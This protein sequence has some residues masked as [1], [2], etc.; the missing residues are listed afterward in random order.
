MHKLREWLDWIES[1]I[2]PTNTEHLPCANHF[3][4]FIFPTLD[5]KINDFCH[6]VVHC[7]DLILKDFS[8]GARQPEF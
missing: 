7:L 4:F 6:P 1:F 3:F 2:L 5:T 8:G